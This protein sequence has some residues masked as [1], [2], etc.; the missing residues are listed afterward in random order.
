EDVGV[1]LGGV[2]LGDRLGV[3]AGGR[4]QVA[5]GPLRQAHERDGCALA[6]VVVRG[7]QGG[8]AAPVVD[9][10]GEVAAQQRHAG[11]VHGGLGRETGELGRVAHDQVVLRAI[12]IEPRFDAVEQVLDAGGVAQ[13][14]AG[15]DAS[16]VEHRAV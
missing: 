8:G 5:G 4:R 12:G 6:E 14:H 10:A 9:G 2:E 15:A 7:G 1:V 16:E 3:L 13:D 11:P